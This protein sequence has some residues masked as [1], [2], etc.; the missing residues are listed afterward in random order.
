M[1][2]LYGRAILRYKNIAF[3]A[4][5]I[6]M[7]SYRNHEMYVNFAM[8]FLYIVNHMIILDKFASEF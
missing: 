6:H 3:T 5:E 7:R 4:N 8:H 1:P 2:A